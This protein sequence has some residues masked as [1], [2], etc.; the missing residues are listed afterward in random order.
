MKTAISNLASSVAIAGLLLVNQGGSTAA[1]ASAAK[2]YIVT[3]AIEGEAAGTARPFE[4][5]SE[6]HVRLRGNIEGGSLRDALL[7]N[8]TIECNRTVCKTIWLDQMEISGDTL[9]I[10]GGGRF[11]DRLPLPFGGWTKVFSQSGSIEVHAKLRAADGKPQVDITKVDFSLGGL[12][13]NVVRLF[14]IDGLLKVAVRPVIQ[15][16]IDAEIAAKMP[17]ANGVVSDLTVEALSF[18]NIAGGLG[19]ATDIKAKILLLPIR[20]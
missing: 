4:L 17:K 14:N 5:G 9:I 19:I 10:R 6:I 18:V 13:G 7:G 2:D 12:F 8:R 20:G 11:E 3:F 1:V 16:K 15:A